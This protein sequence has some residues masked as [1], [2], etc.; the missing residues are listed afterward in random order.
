MCNRETGLEAEVELGIEHA[1]V[2]VI[3]SQGTV[4]DEGILHIQLD[5]LREHVVCAHL[6]IGLCRL[7]ACRLPVEVVACLGIQFVFTTRAMQSA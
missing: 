7:P 1:E 2:V 5:V 4:V 3:L 6:I